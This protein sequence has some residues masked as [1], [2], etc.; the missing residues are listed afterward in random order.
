VSISAGVDGSLWALL[1]EDGVTE[2]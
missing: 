2:Y 1:Y